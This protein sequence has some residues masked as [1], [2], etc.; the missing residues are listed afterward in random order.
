M[1][2]LLLLQMHHTFLYISHQVIEDCRL[3][4]VLDLLD[5]LYTT[6]LHYNY[7]NSI[8]VNIQF[9]FI[10]S[11]C[12]LQ[13]HSIQKK[14]SQTYLPAKVIKMYNKLNITANYYIS[15]ICIRNI[16]KF[17]T[18]SKCLT[19]QNLSAKETTIRIKLISRK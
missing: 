13:F 3:S 12:I 14:S 1:H 17:K 6:Q 4:M 2:I 5:F 15:M 9:R 8:N 7:Y 16:N 18:L 11:C 19:F 10:C